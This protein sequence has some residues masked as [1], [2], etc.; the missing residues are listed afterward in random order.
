MKALRTQLQDLTERVI[1]G[2]LETGRGAVAN[3]L[4][5]TQIKLH[6]YER[7]LKEMTDL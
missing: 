2:D 7:K 4:I 6:E 5:T 1:S 3:Q